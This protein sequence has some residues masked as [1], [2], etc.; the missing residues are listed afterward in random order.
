MTML[1]ML[2]RLV[3][4]FSQEYLQHLYFQQMKTQLLTILL[5]FTK[6]LLRVTLDKLLFLRIIVFSGRSLINSGVLHSIEHHSTGMT[7]K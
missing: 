3:E 2:Q 7:E 1:F 5:K 4:V 6:T